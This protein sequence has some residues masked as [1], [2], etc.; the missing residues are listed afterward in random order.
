MVGFGKAWIGDGEW[1]GCL[2]DGYRHGRC[3]WQQG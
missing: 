3:G 1:K 2:M